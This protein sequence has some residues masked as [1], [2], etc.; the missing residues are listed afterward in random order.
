MQVRKATIQDKKRWNAFIE[1]ESGSFFHYFEW[2]T[3]YEINKWHYIPLILEDNTNDIIGIFP[4]VKI[5][6]FL[7]SIL[8]SL[9]EGA[10]GGF[11]L[12][13]SLTQAEKDQSIQL[14]LN[15]IDQNISNGCSTFHLKENLSLEEGAKSQPT[16]LLV[17]NG[18]K[19]RVYK[20]VQLPCTYR[21]KLSSSFE[22][23]IWYGLWGKYLRNH[24][25]KSQK[26]GV[27]VK[28]DAQLQYKDDYAKM[29]I[30]LYK[31]FDHTPPK[32]EE[33]ILRF[34]TFKD[35]T[36]IWVAIQN[37]APIAFLLCY[38]Y[39]S[40]VCY[41]SKMGYDTLARDNYTTVLLFSEAIGDAC[42]NG[43]QFFEFGTTETTTLA[44]WKEQFK[45]TK[46]PLRI[47]EKTYSPFRSLLWKTPAL[48]RWMFKHKQY[49]WENRR[50]LIRESIM[51]YGKGD[52][53][54]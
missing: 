2:K 36:K 39:Q 4:L 42:E 46:I 49:L 17:K 33:I 23:D 52:R 45:P 5:K 10:S 29:M 11:V 1:A 24:I 32:K 34:T 40:S 18:F 47:Y 12:K 51:K 26:Q 30:A 20:E 43:F 41:A 44:R 13:K 19:P 38:Y 6:R 28:E 22:N 7:H 9:P 8:I 16:I 27:Y 21:L 50:R 31:R 53:F 14:F 3:I 25:R 15:Y 48:I 54:L 35:R 37:D